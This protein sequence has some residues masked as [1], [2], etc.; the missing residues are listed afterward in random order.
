MSSRHP[1]SPWTEAMVTRLEALLTEDSEQNAATIAARLNSEFGTNLTT[2]SV[3]GKI[4]RTAKAVRR[5]TTPSGI[6]LAYI[7]PPKR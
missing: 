3:W 5:T 7:P 6:S 4:N 1:T 2:D